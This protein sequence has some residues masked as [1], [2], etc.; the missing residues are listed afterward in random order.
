MAM[1]KPDLYLK[2]IYEFDYSL[3]QALDIKGILLDMDNTL[4]PWDC[5]VMPQ[6]AK[7]FVRNLQELGFIVCLVSNGKT[8]RVDYKAA[9][10]GI[11]F[12][13]RSLKPTGHG[14][15]KAMRMMQLSRKETAL[16]GDQLFTDMLGANLAGL[17]SV[18]TVPMKSN[19]F[20]GTKINRQL[21]KII[22]RILRL[23]PLDG[24]SAASFLQKKYR[25]KK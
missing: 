8:E 9:D 1:F 4:V 7:D 24:K 14:I 16:L 23:Q 13:S 12:V 6:Q 17:F 5:T 10:L 15:K 11:P 3:L 19:E 21:E 2:S 20:L 22:I 25:H 18:L